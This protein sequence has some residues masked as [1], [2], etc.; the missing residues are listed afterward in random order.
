V[1]S[2]SSVCIVKPAVGVLVTWIQINTL[3]V[4]MEQAP[5]SANSLLLQP[6]LTPH[7]HTHTFK[8]LG[9]Q[10]SFFEEVVSELKLYK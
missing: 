5:G 4:E 9:R 8:V 1:F 7:T 6:K 3:M 2:G 10:V